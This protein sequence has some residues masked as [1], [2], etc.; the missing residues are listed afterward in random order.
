M[1]F[2][3]LSAFI[4]ATTTSF[5]FSYIAVV[6]DAAGEIAFSTFL[7]PLNLEFFWVVILK[8]SQVE[9]FFLIFL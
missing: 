5:A 1:N 7:F 2:C 3:T 9:I 6:G 4:S 8:L